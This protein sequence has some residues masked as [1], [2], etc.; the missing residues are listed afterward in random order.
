MYEGYVV[1]IY[2]VIVTVYYR[3]C[4]I[5][6]K[7]KNQKIRTCVVFA[8]C[9]NRQVKFTKFNKKHPEILY[10]IVF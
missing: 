3:C 4:Q 10:L 8:Y 7:K 5:Y 2:F 9:I 6:V 1:Y